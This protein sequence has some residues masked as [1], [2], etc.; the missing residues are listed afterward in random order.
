MVMLSYLTCRY[1]VGLGDR[2]GENILF[3]S[4]TGECVHVDFN[5]LFCKGEQFD[6]PERVPFRLTHNMVEAL[7]VTGYEGVFRKTCE[8]TLRVMRSECTSLENVLTTF[9]YDPL[10]E[11]SS[12]RHKSVTSSAEFQNEQA[13]ETLRALQNRLLGRDKTKGL[14]LSIEGQVLLLCTCKSC[15]QRPYR[16]IT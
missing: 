9:I 14:P 7:G 1:V 3:D 4:T 11:W 15:S 5:C 13:K 10:V 16:F 8:V 12:G 6:T 2:H